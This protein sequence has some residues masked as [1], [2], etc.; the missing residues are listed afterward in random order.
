MW[1]S[2]LEE[3]GREAGL[4]WY[5]EMENRLRGW[6]GDSSEL[7]KEQYKVEVEGWNNR[8]TTERKVHKLVEYNQEWDFDSVYDAHLELYA[9]CWEDNLVED[10]ADLELERGQEDLTEKSDEEDWEKE[11]TAFD[12]TPLHNYPKLNLLNIH[13]NPWWGKEQ[14]CP[15]DLHASL[16]RRTE[17]KLSISS[18]MK[19]EEGQYD[20]A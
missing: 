1:W 3:G 8:L 10:I 17:Q 4:M 12:Y 11:I 5:Y 13:K 14:F 18:L 9:S 6:N 7:R 19:A 20:D 2:G 16:V 15:A